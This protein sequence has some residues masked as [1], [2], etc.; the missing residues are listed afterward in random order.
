MA[1]ILTPRQKRNKN[2]IQQLE[3]AGFYVYEL[4]PW[5][6]QLV[7]HLLEDFDAIR[8]ILPDLEDGRPYGASFQPYNAP[9]NWDLA[10]VS[11]KMDADPAIVAGR[12]AHEAIHTLNSIFRSRGQHWDLENDEYQA[13]AIEMIVVRTLWG[14]E[15]MIK[16]GA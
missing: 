10:V 14:I 16:N 11:V 3:A 15:R 2:T 9:D 6:V 5:R 7:V 12:V 4:H 13:Y 8:D 1:R